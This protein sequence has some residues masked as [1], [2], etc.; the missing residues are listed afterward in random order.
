KLALDAWM[1]SETAAD[2]P[3]SKVNALVENVASIWRRT[4]AT[5]GTQMIFCDMGVH[6]TQWGYS[7][8]GEVARKLTARGIPREPIAAI[9]DAG[10][11][12]RPPCRGRWRPGAVLRRGEGDCVGQPGR[13][14]A[15]RGR[16]RIAAAL[17]PQEAARRRAVRG[18]PLL[19]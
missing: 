17:G 6:P 12:R 10:R 4:E 9:R 1:L 7:A 8:Y 2:F 11:Q 14:D 3:G 19:A 13:A 5:R 15:G 18:P 16:R